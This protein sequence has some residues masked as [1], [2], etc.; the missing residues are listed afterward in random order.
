MLVQQSQQQ[1]QSNQ[2]KSD[3]KIFIQSI[4]SYIQ[5]EKKLNQLSPPEVEEEILTDYSITQYD[6][7]LEQIN[8]D[9]AMCREFEGN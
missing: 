1:A 9:L 4:S 6:L 7:T 5:I 3:N 8:H 2:I